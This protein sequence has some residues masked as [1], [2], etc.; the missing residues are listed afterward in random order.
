MPQILC[1]YGQPKEPRDLV[2]V[3]NT[4]LP[5]N[6]LLARITK[7]VPDSD[8]TVRVVEIHTPPVPSHVLSPCHTLCLSQANTTYFILL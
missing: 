1:S 5:L 2:L 7:V 6:A 4:S 3:Y 8:C